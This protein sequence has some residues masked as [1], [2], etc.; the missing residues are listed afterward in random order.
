MTIVIQVAHLT[1]FF[2]LKNR[3]FMFCGHGT[4]G[5]VA[6]LLAASLAQW[7]VENIYCYTY[8]AR[9]VWID[10]LT[11]EQQEYFS[12]SSL[13]RRPGSMAAYLTRKRVYVRHNI[14]FDDFVALYGYPVWQYESRPQGGDITQTIFA[15][16]PRIRPT[17]TYLHAGTDKLGSV[18]LFMQPPELC[19]STSLENYDSLRRLF[20][21]DENLHSLKQVQL[22][23][24][25]YDV[26]LHSD[27]FL[28]ALDACLSYS[29]FLAEKLMNELMSDV[30]QT[31]T[32]SQENIGAAA[33]EYQL[34]QHSKGVAQQILSGTA[35]RLLFEKD[36]QL[37]RWTA[38]VGAPN[39]L[40]L[41]NNAT[42]TKKNFVQLMVSFSF[43]E[44]TSSRFFF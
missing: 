12:Y 41:S 26:L 22:V 31:T 29:N 8:A 44:K 28:K 3:R 15:I 2:L 37:L 19:S 7:A 6:S 30:L 35:Y 4:G 9:P 18:A 5:S 17:L 38:F 33:E 20:V 11:K 10:L 34:F 21:G 32:L 25:L 43:Q 42:T 23:A 14:M 13:E 16:P 40:T 27:Y 36:E 24:E 1:V 39:A